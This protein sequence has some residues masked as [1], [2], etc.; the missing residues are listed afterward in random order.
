[1][2]NANL[3]QLLPIL[4]I[5]F[6]PGSATAQEILTN[7]DLIQMHQLGMGESIIKSRIESTNNDFDASTPALMEL[8]RAGLGDELLA[9]VISAS[10]DA[11]RKVVD[12]NDVMAPHRPGIY[13]KDDTGAMQELLPTVTGQTKTKGTLARALSY[14][15]AKST[16]VSRLPGAEARTKFQE[17]KAFYFYFNQQVAS[18]DQNA[19]AFYGFQQAIS[20]NEFN[21]AHLDRSSSARELET[22]SGNNYTSESGIDEKHSRPFDIEQ[23]APGVF[24]V[25]PDPLAAGEYCFVYAGAAP[26]GYGQQK[27]YDF[28]VGLVSGGTMMSQH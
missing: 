9:A 3:L 19:I 2:K 24:K 6:M 13:Y 28:S 22:G 16:I 11:T 18:F 1:M 23:L 10:K 27:V 7:K 26:Y 4:L 8:K 14:G 5:W 17:T 12:A 20:P 21:L 15:I 25:T